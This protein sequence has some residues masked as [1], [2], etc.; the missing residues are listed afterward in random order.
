MGLQSHHREGQCISKT[1]G[2]EDGFNRAIEE[3]PQ[4]DSPGT[5]AKMQSGEQQ[6]YEK[7]RVSC[8]LQCNSLRGEVLI[9]HMNLLFTIFLK[10]D[11]QNGLLCC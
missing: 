7:V 4:E 6:W 8:F 2:K 1:T 11:R 3:R 9:I 10:N 5:E